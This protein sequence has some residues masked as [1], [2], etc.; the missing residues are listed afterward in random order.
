MSRYRTLVDL[1]GET[2]AI[3]Y[4]ERGKKHL[5][6][7][8]LFNSNRSSITIQFDEAV[9]LCEA[10]QVFVEESKSVK[11]LSNSVIEEGKRK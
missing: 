9:I 7:V 5:S 10:L 4:H 6:W 3:V 2:V 8:R 1:S 11:E